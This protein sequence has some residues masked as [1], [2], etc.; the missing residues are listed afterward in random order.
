MKVKT[1]I[2]HGENLPALY[3]CWEN[4]NNISI[5][6]RVEEDFVVYMTISVDIFFFFLQNIHTQYLFLPLHELNVLNITLVDT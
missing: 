2:S 3:L 4:V 5:Y 6:L 1:F